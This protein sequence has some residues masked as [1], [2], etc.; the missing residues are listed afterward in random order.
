M[1]KSFRLVIRGVINIILLLIF[2][3]PFYWMALTA[4]KSLSQTLQSPPVF[5][6]KS[7]QWDNFVTAFNEIEFMRFFKNSIIQ[8]LGII[9]A[10]LLTVVPAAYA[11]ARYD[12]KGKGGGSGEA[13]QDEL[14]MELVNKILI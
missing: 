2:F 13:G 3:V 14:L 9:I 4:I 12:F 1:N 10:Q 11:F 7:P 8:T 5:F 6:V